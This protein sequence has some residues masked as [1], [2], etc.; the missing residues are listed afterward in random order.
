MTNF[1]NA[2]LKFDKIISTEAVANFTFKRVLYT[3]FAPVYRKKQ[4]NKKNWSTQIVID[5]NDESFRYQS[6]LGLPTFFSEM[7]A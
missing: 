4:K 5:N 1:R 7:P 6:R 3:N 2:P